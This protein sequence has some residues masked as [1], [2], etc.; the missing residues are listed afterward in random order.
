[1]IK[2]ASIP[3]DFSCIDHMVNDRP[4][5]CFLHAYD[6]FN[7]YH[8]LLLHSP[9]HHPYL[10]PSP[11]QGGVPAAEHIRDCLRL[12]RVAHLASPALT[13]AA[14]GNLP[15]T[16]LESWGIPASPP[17]P[18]SFPPAASASQQAPTPDM[19][20]GDSQLIQHD[21]VV[22]SGGAGKALE[23]AFTLVSRLF[24]PRSAA[25]LACELLAPDFSQ[26]DP[27]AWK[28][29]I[30]PDGPVKMDGQDASV[31]MIVADGTEE[32][33]AMVPLDVLTRAGANVTVASAEEEREIRGEQGIRIVAHC[34]VTDVPDGY[35]Y[36]ALVLPGGSGMGGK[37]V[38]SA[39]VRELVTRHAKARRLIGAIGTSTLL[40]QHVGVLDG[41]KWTMPPLVAD[42]LTAATSALHAHVVVDGNVVTSRGTGTAMEFALL[43]AH[44][45]YGG[46]I[47][48]V[49]EQELSV[50][51]RSI[52]A[53]VAV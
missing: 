34:L 52:R 20:A 25:A 8:T 45:L 12:Q 22:T 18:S 44:C 21:R 9:P 23:L 24:G 1:M 10:I 35:V 19:T 42:Q 49:V 27:S 40:L 50:D 15:A 29:A 39:A 17:N 47:V 48:E 30:S 43:L 6:A 4:N 16:I 33:E 37:L 7:T 5:Q 38:D 41:R 2:C 11:S 46:N 28:V 36:D 53:V 51:D 32:M 13:L 31:L 3:L 14:A 26:S